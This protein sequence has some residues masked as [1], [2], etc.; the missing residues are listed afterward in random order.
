MK[1][2]MLTERVFFFKWSIQKTIKANGVKVT[3]N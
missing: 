3:Q 2:M 1:I